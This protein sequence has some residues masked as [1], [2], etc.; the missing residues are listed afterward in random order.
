[1][2]FL[3]SLLVRRLLVNTVGNRIKFA[4]DVSS[5][6]RAINILNEKLQLGEYLDA[7]DICE[8]LVANFPRKRLPLFSTIYDPF[9][10]LFL[11]KV[12]SF[13]FYKPG[14]LV[15]A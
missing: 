7:L 10:K 13:N 9:I 12:T 6:D 4:L 2:R 5:L 8:R 3:K 1:M 11:T 15:L 14:N